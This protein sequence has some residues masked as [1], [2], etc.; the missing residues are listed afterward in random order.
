ML[1]S[2]GTSSDKQ[3]SGGLKRTPEHGIWSKLRVR[4]NAQGAVE[5]YIE[6][7]YWTFR[8]HSNWLEPRDRQND[9]V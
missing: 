8:E 2:G 6:K 1:C 3:R 4:K 9:G 5:F 7:T